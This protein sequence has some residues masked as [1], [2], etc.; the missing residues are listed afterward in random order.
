MSWHWVYETADGEQSD[1]SPG[2]DNRS[3]AES[4]IGLEF[5]DLLKRGVDRVRLFDGV[6]EIY[7]PMSLHA[8]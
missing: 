4:F 7:G 6:K 8:A 5:E 1:T 2:F 3:D